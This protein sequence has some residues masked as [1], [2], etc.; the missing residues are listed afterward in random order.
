MEKKRFLTFVAE[1]MKGMISYD[2]MMAAIQR[3]CMRAEA[4]NLELLRLGQERVDSLIE[5]ITGIG[6][7]NVPD[8]VL[9][10]LVLRYLKNTQFLAS[11]K[12]E[13]IDVSSLNGDLDYWKKTMLFRAP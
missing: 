6:A 3:S 11:L 2:T 12:E 5:G 4:E 9:D 13:D 10:I 8:D 1:V 7:L